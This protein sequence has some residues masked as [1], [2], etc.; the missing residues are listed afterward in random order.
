MESCKFDV[1]RHDFAMM[2]P[3]VPDDSIAADLGPHRPRDIPGLSELRAVHKS[4][5]SFVN[6]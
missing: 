1:L 2:Q 4:L 5:A 3:N 6:Q